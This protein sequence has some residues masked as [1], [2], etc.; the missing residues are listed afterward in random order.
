MP[1]QIQYRW[2]LRCSG[3][4]VTSASSA[5]FRLCKEGFDG[6][7]CEGVAAYACWSSGAACG[8]NRRRACS[9]RGQ[10]CDTNL[11]F[12][13]RREVSIRFQWVCHRFDPTHRVPLT[14]MLVTWDGSLTDKHESD[15]TQSGRTRYCVAL[16]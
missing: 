13:E 11:E 3:H 10:V 6:A 5:P 1:T 12:L 14:R 15:Q 9:H 8:S 7:Q 2:L 4:V 16:T